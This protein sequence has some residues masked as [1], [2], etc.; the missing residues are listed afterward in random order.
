MRFELTHTLYTAL[1]GQRLN[2]SAKVPCLGDG[3]ETPIEYKYHLRFE[4]YFTQR[5]G[6]AETEDLTSWC[7]CTCGLHSCRVIWRSCIDIWAMPGKL[8]RTITRHGI[9]FQYQ[10]VQ[11]EN[12]RM[13][14]QMKYS[15]QYLPWWTFEEDK[16]G[17]LSPV[18]ITTRRKNK[19]N[20][21]LWDLN[22]R[23]HCTLP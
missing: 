5:R 10:Y 23:I 12:I 19:I 15:Y 20:R 21:H 17:L 3:S 1:A 13:R 16:S 11:T 18:E 6:N 9:V 14:K 4:K 7:E 22:S 2:H 8:F